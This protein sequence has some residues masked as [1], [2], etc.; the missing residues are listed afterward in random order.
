MVPKNVRKFAPKSQSEK[1]A[2]R[3][4]KALDRAGTAVLEGKPDKAK[5][6]VEKAKKG[7]KPSERQASAVLA[8]IHSL[9]MQVTALDHKIEGVKEHYKELKSTRERLISRIRGEARDMGQGRLEFDN[10]KPKTGGAAEGAAPANAEGKEPDSKAKDGA[11]D[12]V[13]DREL[14]GD[15]GLEQE[16]KASTSKAKR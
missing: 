10:E 11:T 16:S 14:G 9:E 5:K 6:I 15:D 1:A 7:K 8:E 3:K 2:D 12:D 13:I 4:S